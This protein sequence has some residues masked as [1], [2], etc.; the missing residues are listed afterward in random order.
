MEDLNNINVFVALFTT[1]NGRMQLYG[2]LDRLQKYVALYGLCGYID[3]VTNTLK[4]G[5]TLGEWSAINLVRMDQLM[6][7]SAQ[8]KR[9]MLM[10]QIKVKVT[11]R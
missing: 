2:M 1:A 3:N 11:A 10:K 8:D 5:C 7:G 9:V 6:T 4:I